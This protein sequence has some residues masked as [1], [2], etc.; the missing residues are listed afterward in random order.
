[1]PTHND[2]HEAVPGNGGDLDPRQA[3]TL[4]DQTTRRVRRQFDPHPPV[5][6]LGAALVVLIAYGAIWLSVRNQHPYVGP[7]LAA[8]AV[9]YGTVITWAV[10]VSL[11]QRRAVS[12]ISGRSQMRR[13]REGA[14]FGI[15]W[16]VVYVFQGALHH[17]GA[18]HA[19]TYGIYP[20]TA[21]LIVLGSASATHQAAHE[22]W[23]WAGFAAAAVV[24]GGLAAYAGPWSVWAVVGVALAILLLARGAV[25]VWLHG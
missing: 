10:A 8:L 6:M 17:A 23:E 13:R 15:A 1:M 25:Q 24:I 11:V 16:A 21:P 3:A 5:L 14:A 19:I 20:A 2:T 18:S 12:G 7:S 22:N 4:L 9:L